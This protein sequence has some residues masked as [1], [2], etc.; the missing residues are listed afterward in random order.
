MQGLA[1]TACRLIAISTAADAPQCMSEW[2]R[3]HLCTICATCLGGCTVNMYASQLRCHSKIRA[4]DS[5]CSK[6]PEACVLPTAAP[7]PTAPPSPPPRTASRPPT[8]T[9]SAHQPPA[10]RT[11]TIRAAATLLRSSVPPAVLCNVLRLHL[12]CQLH[13][14]TDTLWCGVCRYQESFYHGFAVL[15]VRRKYATSTW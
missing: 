1:S 13:C 10:C 11:Q 5:L 6:R 14:A 9:S 7:T 4:S 3:L 15:D 2:R 12:T 8:P